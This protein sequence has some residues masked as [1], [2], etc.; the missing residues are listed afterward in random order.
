VT[1]SAHARYATRLDALRADEVVLSAVERLDPAGGRRLERDY[2]RFHPGREPFA[3]LVLR[4]A[5]EPV[6]RVDA[7]DRAPAM[8]PFVAS[9]AGWLRV[10]AVASDPALPSLTRLLSRPARQVVVRYRPGRRCTVRFE[11]RYAK[12]FADGRGNRLRQD[13]EILWAAR[14]ELGFNVPRPERYDPA[15]RTLWLSRVPGRPAGSIPRDAAVARRM[16]QALASLST[17]DVRP[18]RVLD[19]AATLARSAH[20]G[21]TLVGSVPA[22]E[23]PVHDLLARLRRGHQV[24]RRRLAPVHGNPHAGQ[25]LDGDAGLGLV[26]FDGLA[27]GDPEIDVASVL[28]ALDFEDPA[29]VPVELLR[30]NFLAGYLEGGPALDARL[31]AVH[32]AHRRLAK[33]ARV[34]ASLRPDG[35][36][37]AARHVEGALR[38]LEGVT[39]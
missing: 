16:G 36:R 5:L 31:I 20:L 4:D 38:E 25:W 29:R 17:A 12:V 19:P 23:R 21:E 3:T 35:D 7:Y 8:P 39:A 10:S 30:A 33:A 14:G 11:R 26:D 1:T 15:E 9:D 18:R 28:A 32:R 37:R 13:G 22:L 6:L 2:A 24:G 34:A 27:L